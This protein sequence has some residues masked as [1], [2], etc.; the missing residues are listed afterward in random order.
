M[1]VV[2]KGSS[3]N[4]PTRDIQKKVSQTKAPRELGLF[5]LCSGAQNM[6]PHSANF[7]VILLGKKNSNI[8]WKTFNPIVSSGMY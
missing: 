7:A 8:L 6:N 3:I 4:H 1:D 2:Y 5:A